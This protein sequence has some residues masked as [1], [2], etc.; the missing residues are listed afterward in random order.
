MFRDNKGEIIPYNNSDCILRTADF[1]NTHPVFSLNE[2]A[3]DLAPAGGR[4]G[5][6]RKPLTSSGF[7]INSKSIPICPDKAI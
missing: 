2:A 4:K 5:Y 1:F 3:R 6:E 7:S